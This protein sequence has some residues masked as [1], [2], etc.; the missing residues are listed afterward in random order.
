M[1]NGVI[2]MLRMEISDSRKAYLGGECKGDNF[3]RFVGRNSKTKIDR[4]SKTDRHNE[5]N[6]KCY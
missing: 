6:N 2:D 4:E 3:L 5:T 1:V